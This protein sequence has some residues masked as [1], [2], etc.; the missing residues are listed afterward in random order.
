MLDDL[1]TFE[2]PE[3]EERESP[4][5]VRGMHFSLGAVARRPSGPKEE[6]LR[7]PLASIFYVVWSLLGFL[8]GSN[9]RIVDRG[10]GRNGHG[11]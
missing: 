5:D 9:E 6:V 1:T 11:V 8:V 10:C 2:H 4:E 7:L 3:R